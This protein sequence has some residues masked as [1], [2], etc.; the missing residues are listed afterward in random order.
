VWNEPVVKPALLG[1]LMW[2]GIG[3][4]IMHRMVRFAV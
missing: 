1:A 4:I 2:L 3:N